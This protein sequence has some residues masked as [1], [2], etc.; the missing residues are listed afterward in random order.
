[1]SKSSGPRLSIIPAAF[2]AD[3][4]ASIVHFRVLNLLGRHTDDH[5]WCVRSQIKMAKEIGFS[6]E[7]V[8]RA[9][10][11]LVEWGYVEKTG[12]GT[13]RQSVCFYRVILDPKVQPMAAVDNEGECE[14]EITG[15]V[16]PEIT[17]GVTLGITGGVISTDHTITTPVKRPLLNEKSAP[18]RASDGNARAPTAKKTKPTVFRPWHTI[19]SHDSS[20]DAWIEHLQRLGREE[21]ADAAVKAGWLSARS[22]WPK[23]DDELPNVDQDALASLGVER[24][25][26]GE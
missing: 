26:G 17:G 9:I 4:R 18:E 25:V 13:T 16:I 8:N 20:F 24:M 2:A 22:L 21:L 12:Q 14:A 19:T 7:T 10:K 3:A 11:D 23:E 15:G 1:M 6:R 5:G